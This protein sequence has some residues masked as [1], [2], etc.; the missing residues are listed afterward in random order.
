MSIEKIN[1]I[2]EQVAATTYAAF[3]DDA[4]QIAPLIRLWLRDDWLNQLHPAFTAS[5]PT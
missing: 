4:A 1:A 5:H 3:V 2:G